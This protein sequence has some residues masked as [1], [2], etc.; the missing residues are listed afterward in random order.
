MN[1]DIYSFSIKEVT[2][3]DFKKFMKT[4]EIRLKKLKLAKGE[5]AVI[6]KVGKLKN[7]VVSVYW[8]RHKKFFWFHFLLGKFRWFLNV[9]NFMKIQSN[10]KQQKSKNLECLDFCFLQDHR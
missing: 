1:S 5:I 10:Q 8:S 6:L 4:L 2:Q 9:L 3:A 7:F